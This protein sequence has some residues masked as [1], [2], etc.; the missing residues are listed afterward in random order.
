MT[1]HRPPRVFISSTLED[2]KTHRAKAVEAVL[3]LGWQPIDCGYWAAGGNPPLAT[4]LERVEQADVVVCLVARR[5]GWTPPD[6]H[7]GEHKSI[8]RL[9]CE[10]AHRRG[11]AI[12]P[13]LL[14][15]SVLWDGKLCEYARLEQEADQAAEIV[16][17]VQAL[18]DFKTWLDGIA[19][20]SQFASADQLCTEV[21]HALSE[22]GK[23]QGHADAS[24][25]H[26]ATL[27]AYLAWLRRE[28]E[29]VELLGLDPKDSQ[30]VRLGQVYVP[31]VTA[32]KEKPDERTPRRPWQGPALDRL[33]H[34]LG[35]E[36]LYLPGAPG[37]GKSTFCRWLALVVASGEVP[38]HPVAVPEG[39]E[40]Q[41]PDAL[42]GRF[43]LLVRLRE[44][45]DSEARL[46]GNGRWS[47]ARLRAALADWLDQSRP[48]GLDARSFDARI[49]A[50]PCLLIFDGVDEV[51]EAIG[52]DRPRQNLLSGLADALPGWLDAGHR[53]LLTSRPYGLGPEDRRRLG[54]PV[55]ELA[56]LPDELQH[57]FV[58]RW[59]AAADP[60]RAQ[61]KADGLLGHLAE[62]DDL[63][64]LSAN[65]MLLTALCVKYDEGRRLPRDF[66]RLYQS[67]VD[68]VLHKRYLTEPEREAAARRL[69]AVALGLHRGTPARPRTSPA[70]EA[71]YD[72]ID[73]ILAGLAASDPT[74]EDG[75]AAAAG[76]RDGLLGDSGLLLPRGE[77]RAG[78]YH[79][80]FQEYF[81]ARRLHRLHRLREPV[82]DILAR[83]AASAD[84]RRT[85][86]LL[87][88]AL[89][90][91]DSPEGAMTGF[92]PLAAS[93]EPDRLGSG[94][95]P[96]LL[97]ADCLEIAHTHTWQI[98]EFAPA[99]KTA[100]EAALTILPPAPRAQ[101]WST[102]GVLGL[103][104]RPG[105]GLHDG[106][107]DIDWVDIP[108]GDFLYGEDK[109]R[110]SLGAYRIARHPVT[111]AQFQ[112]F[113]D[114]GDGYRDARWW[115]GLGEP[116]GAAPARWPRPTHP[117][118]M[119]SWFEATAFCRWLDARLRAAGR[120]DGEAVV[121][122]QSEHE[123]EKAARGIDGR[124]YPWGEFE[125]G[126][127][128]INERFRDVGPNF[129]GQTSPVGI[130][131]A[132]ASPAGVLDLAGNVWE[133]CADLYDKDNDESNAPRVLRG[134]SWPFTHLVCRAASRGGDEPGLR[135]D[136]VGFR[137]CFAPPI[138]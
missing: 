46:A 106:L 113:V 126:R 10:A 87:F 138:A 128:N 104:E 22:W 54:L 21:F 130:Y 101:L 80:S 41:L 42:R 62:R 78:F 28:C 15:D 49:K 16:R 97:L 1:E 5:H 75:A 29:S 61:D 67:L 122:L 114:D 89:A 55:A 73:D 18:K 98:G 3:K 76:L 109:Q 115:H 93:L 45:A 9:E 83:H 105:I 103:D 86:T 70:A 68:Q 91:L 81:A 48:G 116:P 32:P 84:W 37:A 72:E 35:E 119:V 20:R 90:D 64:P 117:R 127:A 88:C 51:P 111:H 50:G 24:S 31:A 92:A 79:L 58:R 4:C 112:A 135:L 14:D 136:Y 27:E 74:T 102:L 11:V 6:Q 71:G 39:F 125:A 69:A 120:L 129:L 63:A 12:L 96:A 137:V 57:A 94:P 17:N 47:A 108:A 8:T 77:R 2:L 95:E 65:P 133:W 40:E 59:Y 44:W 53:V 110:A 23:R 25:G 118:E 66:F 100:C 134:G 36:S 121:R 19:T 131:P 123:R 43:P 33:L 13:F 107:P 99:L 52:A 56:E 132:G 124:D 85:L 60:A 7:A 30:N 26:A 82:A 38:A 34:R